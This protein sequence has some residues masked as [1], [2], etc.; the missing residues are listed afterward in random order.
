V[1]PAS[2]SQR[3]RKLTL[4]LILPFFA[5]ILAMIVYFGAV[6]IQSRKSD[7]DTTRDLEKKTEIMVRYLAVALADTLTMGEIDRANTIIR[8]AKAIDGDVINIWVVG[9]D[10]RV[11]A[12]ADPSTPSDAMPAHERMRYSGALADFAFEQA[13]DPSV[14]AAVAP[15]WFQA[16]RIGLV[17]IAVS[18][19]RVRQ[20]TIQAIRTFSVVGII[21]LL[22]GVTIYGFA[23]ER[24]ARSN[25]MLLD[26]VQE[27][28]LNMEGKVKERTLELAQANDQ[29]QRRSRE[30]AR[31]VEEL[32]ALGEVGQAVNSSVDLETVLNTIV[33]HA[34]QL[35]DTDGGALYEFDEIRE[36]FELRATHGMSQDLIGAVQEARIRLGETAVGRAALKRE[37]VQIADIRNEPS[38]PLRDIMERAGFRALLAV[39]LLRA[40]RIIG[41]L[42]VRR[43]KP[44][45]FAKEAV[46]LLQTF[47]TQSVLA[48]Q[49]A[50]LFQ[51]IEDKSK[52]VEAASRHKSEF[53]ANMSHELRTPLNA[54]LG[55][56][57]LILGGIYG[58]VPAELRGPLTD[59]QNSGKHLLRLINNVLDVAKIE[60]GRMELA[61]AEYSV[62]DTVESVR[63]SLR[64]LAADKGLEFVARDSG[65]I[66]LAYGDGGRITQCLM[67]LAGNA[68]KFTREGRVEI[69]AELQGDH[70]VY[71]VGDTGIGIAP[72]KLETVFAEFRQGDATVTSEF[73][74]TGLG[75]SITK[76]FV[77]MHG[78]RIWVESELGKGSR[79]F[80]EIPL[81]L[82]G[83]NPA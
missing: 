73:G 57:E 70:L 18:R 69:S 42:V 34:V 1:A 61:L 60:A 75:L 83:E 39:P 78:G 29:L 22:L 25:A 66:P 19:E 47:A 74:G 26:Q 14:F 31:S 11:I 49:N 82:D 13:G 52:Q 3:H 43:R 36:E 27:F 20:G 44:G 4:R 38:Y 15:I 58:A 77:E 79:F 80:F 53:L 32:R 68:L 67:N 56:N 35:S 50:R 55:F 30:L 64:P 41:A 5:I 76:R 9:I 24:V 54:I 6:N 63:T 48:I 45:Y 28:G 71:C 46:E 17:R 10:G 81:R 12:S 2:S 62:Q 33:A 40:D 8:S 65:E 37:A 72:D 51:E 7:T 59:I 21:A 23:A 16:S